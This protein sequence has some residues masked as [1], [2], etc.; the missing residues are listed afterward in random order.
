MHKL[1]RINELKLGLENPNSF[2]TEQAKV[3]C[4]SKTSYNHFQNLK[5]EPENEQGI[6]SL[7]HNSLCS[8]QIQI[9][10]P[11]GKAKERKNQLLKRLRDYD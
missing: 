11:T 3:R 1:F 2:L 10:Q 8:N 9:L 7:K 4:N 5:G 6:N